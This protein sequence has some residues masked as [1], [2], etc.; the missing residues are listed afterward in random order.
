MVTL[1]FSPC[2]K[3][4]INAG[5]FINFQFYKLIPRQLLKVTSEFLL[6]VIIVQML[7]YL[8]CVLCRCHSSWCANYTS[9]SIVCYFTLAMSFKRVSSSLY[10]R[11]ILYISCSSLEIIDFP[12]SLNVIVL[13]SLLNIS[14]GRARN[15]SSSRLCSC[16][17]TC[18]C[19]RPFHLFQSQ[20]A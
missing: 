4:R 17:G 6:G 14:G 3:G 9:L 19:S 2:R 13:F 20:E 11:F 1:K 5:V 15:E 16:T 7:M 12:W 8:I 10:S 18:I